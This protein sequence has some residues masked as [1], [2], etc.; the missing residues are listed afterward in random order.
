MISFFGLM[1]NS[2]T[3]THNTVSSSS[4]SFFSNWLPIEVGSWLINCRLR[5]FNR[6]VGVRDC[7]RY[8]M[9]TSSSPKNDNRNVVLDSEVNY[10]EVLELCLS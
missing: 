9:H 7:C 6:G 8:E 4:V 2:I 1:D 5:D 10:P 3:F